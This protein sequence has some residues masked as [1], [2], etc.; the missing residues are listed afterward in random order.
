MILSNSF[1]EFLAKKTLNTILTKDFSDVPGLFADIE[2]LLQGIIT[3]P[4]NLSQ[5]SNNDDKENALY[6]VRTIL[7]RL[8]IEFGE[9][10]FIEDDDYEDDEYD[11]DD[12]DDEDEEEDEPF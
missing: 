2:R 8:N 6:L 12:E 7:E 4:E 1:E 3:G 11:D 10:L 5:S 9:E